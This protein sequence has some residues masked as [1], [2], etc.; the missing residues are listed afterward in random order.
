MVWFAGGPGGSSMLDL[1]IGLGPFKVDADLNITYNP[2]SFTNRSSV[3]YIDN[4][5]GVGYSYVSR[6]I[7]YTQTD[8]QVSMDAFNMLEQFFAAWP[9][10]RSNTLF[11]AGHSYGGVYAPYLAW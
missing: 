11:I 10:L 6:A 7:D 8:L 1:F 5:A 3:L 4:P 2:Y 9:E